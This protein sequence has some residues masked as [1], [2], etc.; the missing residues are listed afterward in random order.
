MLIPGGITKGFTDREK[1]MM[2]EVQTTIMKPRLLIKGEDV[3][4]TSLAAAEAFGKRHDN[5]LR[6]VEDLLRFEEMSGSDLQ[7]PGVIDKFLRANFLASS[8]VDQYDRPQPMYT[9][10]KDGFTL[11]V[12]GYTGRQAMRFK[13]AYINSFNAMARTLIERRIQN[14]Q[15]VSD[16]QFAAVGLAQLLPVCGGHRAPAQIL[17]YLLRCGAAEDWV[18]VSIRTIMAGVVGGPIGTGGVHFGLKQLKTFGFV[19]SGCGPKRYTGYY[20]VILNALELKLGEGY[21]NLRANVTGVI[22]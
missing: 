5:V 17:E 2:I 21:L 20:R 18:Q 6:D 13:V 4:T 10:T 16:A 19:E 7:K 15:K 8:Y 1:D 22:H 14:V 11:L 3:R 12:M 9:M